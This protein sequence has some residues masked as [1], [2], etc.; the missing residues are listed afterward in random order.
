M[1]YP[2]QRAI[3][4]LYI[5]KN[6]LVDSLLFIIIFTFTFFEICMWYSWPYSGWGSHQPGRR[7]WGRA[8][9]LPKLVLVSPKQLYCNNA[10]N[11]T[12]N[13]LIQWKN[14]KV[15]SYLAWGQV[16]INRQEM[17]TCEEGDERCLWIQLDNGSSYFGAPSNS[18]GFY[19]SKFSMLDI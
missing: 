10:L 5:N 4:S 8:G 16:R 17:A 11:R 18:S 19:D 1:E 3:I 14:D 2:L 13:V 7:E 12:E 9:L 6:Y 15:E